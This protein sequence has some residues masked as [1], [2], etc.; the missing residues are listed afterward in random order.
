VA[1]VPLTSA[2]EEAV[3]A[4]LGEVLRHRLLVATFGD[5][6]LELAEGPDGQQRVGVVQRPDHMNE[7]QLV[8]Q[9]ELSGA[10]GVRTRQRARATMASR[11]PRLDRDRASLPRSVRQR[12]LAA[13]FAT[14]F[15]NHDID[16]V[17]ALLTDDAW[18]TMPPVT[19]EYQGSAAIGAFLRDVSV[20]FGGRPYQLV[21]TGANGQPAY[22]LYIPDGSAPEFRAYGLVVLTL[23]GDR[24]SAITPLCRQWPDELVRAAELAGGVAVRRG[25]SDRSV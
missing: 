16:G 7:G 22:G 6:G 25:T 4:Y 10:G 5:A 12:D 18:I 2:S 23:E 17:V 19:L 8:V 21:P 15:A 20:W 13:R 3:G 9:P 24:I 1:G 11:L 14:A